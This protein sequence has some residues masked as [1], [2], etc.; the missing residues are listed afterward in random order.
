MKRSLF[1]FIPVLLLYF[2]NTAAFACTIFMA[3]DGESVIAGNNEDFFYQYSSDMWFVPASEG[4]YG[5]VCFGNSRYI[6]GGMNEKG[7]FYDGATCPDTQVPNDADK[8]TLG[9]DMGDVLLAK[10]A[11]VNE[12]VEILKE[13]NAPGGDHLLLADA[14]G[15]SVVIEWVENEMKVISREGNH[16]TVTN[17]FISKPDLGGYPCSRYE[18]VEK[19]LQS[20]TEITVDRFEKILESASQ[21]W[22]GGGTKYSNVYDLK[23]KIV[24]VYNRGDF[25]SYAVFQL[26]NELK[27][28]KDG[29]R[30]MYDIESLAFHG[31]GVIDP[32]VTQTEKPAA[33]DEAELAKSDVD[34]ASSSRF[35]WLIGFLVFTAYIAIIVSIYR[36][37]SQRHMN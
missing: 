32:S 4:S 23:N 34:K 6:Q 9:M 8:P 19:M 33:K 22:E 18:T 10:C 25:S 27:K 37:K 29:S 35:A 28:M 5:R 1:I 24:Y 12:A 20:S 17:F 3:S 26:D 7:L 13:H 11:N 14:N 2:F 36:C 16:Q 21:S 31:E 30:M 15:N